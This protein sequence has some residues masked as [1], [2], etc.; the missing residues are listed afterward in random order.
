VGD[1]KKFSSVEHHHVSLYGFDTH[2]FIPATRP[3]CIID[4]YSLCDPTPIRILR[5]ADTYRKDGL[6]GSKLFKFWPVVTN[7]TKIRTPDL[8]FFRR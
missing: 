7:E 3:H 6:S 8:S 5:S 4:Q 2:M 1:L